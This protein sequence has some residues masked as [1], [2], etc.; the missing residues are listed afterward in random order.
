MKSGLESKWCVLRDHDFVAHDV[1]A[2][3]SVVHVV[4][5]DVVHDV[6]LAICCEQH[7]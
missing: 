7:C 5:Y 1:V 3:D 4:V 2:H 6:H